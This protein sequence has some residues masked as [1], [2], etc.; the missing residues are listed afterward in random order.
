MRAA[1]LAPPILFFLVAC[2]GGGGTQSSTAPVVLPPVARAGPDQAVPSGASVMH[3]GSTSTDPNGLSLS[4]AWTAPAGIT[5]SNPAATKPTFT[6]PSLAPGLPPAILAFSLV[7]SDGQASSAPSSVTVTVNPPAP[8]NPP[9]TASAGSNQSVASGAAVTLDGALSSDLD[10]QALSY[11]WAQAGG[12]PVTLAGATTAHPT[13]TAPTVSPGS[14]AVALPFSL[15]VSDANASSVPATVSV[16]VNP[17]GGTAYPP[18]PGTPTPATADPNPLPVGGSGSRRW[19]IGA[20]GGGLYLVDPAAG[21]ASVQGLVI[22]T[23]DKGFPPADTVVTINGLALVHA[24]PSDDRYFKVDPNGT[25]PPVHP[26]GRMILAASSASAGVAR[27]L[28]LPCATDVAV[29]T[30]PAVGASLATVTNLQLTFSSDLT[31]NPAGIVSLAGITPTTML[32]GYDAAT[33]TFTA[34]SPHAV[35]AG[36]L[37]LTFPVGT[38]PA[39]TWLIDLRWPGLFIPDG[40]DSGAFCG[41]AKRWTYAK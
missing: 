18:P 11:A 5:L 9:P 32:G 36:Q 34:G 38:T 16:T 17:A 3:D 23:L 8:P 19:Q 31:L 4:Y 30:T 25:Q 28:V 24:P 35:G 20:V 40:G 27:Q 41:L 6:A 12:P 1:H 29:G 14:S 33:R 39:Q 13:F 7:V 15:V 10:G 37:G 22:V 21:E 2:G 26:G